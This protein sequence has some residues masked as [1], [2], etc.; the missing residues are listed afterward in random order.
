MKFNLDGTDMIYSTYLGEGGTQGFDIA[1]DDN[2]EAYV[3]GQTASPIFPV[4][5][6][7]FDETYNGIWDGFVSRLDSQAVTYFFDL[8]GWY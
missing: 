2:G 1:V 6:G 5:S 4:T 8:P 3:T 7:A